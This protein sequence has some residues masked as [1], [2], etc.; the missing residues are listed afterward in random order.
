MFLISARAA[1]SGRTVMPR[2]R[3][4][5]PFKK[6]TLVKLIVFPTGAALSFKILSSDPLEAV[7]GY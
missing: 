2:P 1:I 5:H 3:I 4:A 7:Q 6:E